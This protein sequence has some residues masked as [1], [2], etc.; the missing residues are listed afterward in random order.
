MTASIHQFRSRGAT[1]TQYIVPSPMPQRGTTTR[2]PLLQDE[3]SVD[4]VPSTVAWA[5]L[6]EVFIAAEAARL[7]KATVRVSSIFADCLA[8]W[9]ADTQFTSSATEIVLHPSYQRIIGLG[10][11]VLPFI[12][13]ELQKD[14]AHWYSA[15]TSLTGANPVRS[16]DKGRVKK[17]K[18]AWLAWAA[19]NGYLDP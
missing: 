9:K 10:P 12:F 18:E 4:S 6:A 11:E 2:S 8:K 16:E 3:Y 19:D 1:S 15:L 5:A 13:C 17:M 14:G 7:R